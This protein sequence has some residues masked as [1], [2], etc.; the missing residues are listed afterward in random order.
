[1]GFSSMASD[2]DVA[3]C[4]MAG[5]VARQNET[6]MGFLGIFIKQRIMDRVGNP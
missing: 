4:R 2:A 6:Q 3:G 5:G 1:M